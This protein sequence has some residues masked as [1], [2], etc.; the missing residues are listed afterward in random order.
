ML[1]TQYISIDNGDMEQKLPGKLECSMQRMWYLGAY[2]GHL[3]R[4]PQQH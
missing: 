3:P 1:D 2:R 4:F